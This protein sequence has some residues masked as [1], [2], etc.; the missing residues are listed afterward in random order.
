MC[1]RYTLTLERD[2][3]EDR[4]GVTVD[5]S[6]TPRYN[7]APGQKL[8]VITSDAPEAVQHLEWGLVPRGPTTTPAG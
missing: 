8:P 6:Y 3:L 1:G 4:F 7:A 2:D 5:D